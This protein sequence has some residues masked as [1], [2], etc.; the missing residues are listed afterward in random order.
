L[1]SLYHARSTGFRRRG[2][3]YVDGYGSATFVQKDVSAGGA[4]FDMGVYH[5]AQLV[6]L[7]GLP[8]V[9]RIS[10]K[11]YQETEMDPKRRDESGYNVEELGLGLVRFE[12]GLTMDIIEAWAIHLDGFEGSS[13]VGSKG[14]I[15]LEPFGFYS[16]FCDMNMNSQLD[17]KYME[18]RNH[19]LGN[20][21]DAYDSSQKHW[22]AAQQG[23][24]PLLPTAEV[25]L[26]T[27]LIQ[28]GIY[29]SDSLGREVDKEEVERASETK[30]IAI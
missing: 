27:M 8:S 22:I 17:L 12:N 24:V 30:A 9:E 21:E 6:Y 1:G 19:Q 16:T 3:P 20:N 14:G 26:T 13:I 7:L 11:V 23:R 25:A 10:G 5:I 15:R 2:R 28:E 4:M 29:L 18:Y